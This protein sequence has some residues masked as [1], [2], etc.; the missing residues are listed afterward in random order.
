MK[1]PDGVGAK[2]KAKAKAKVTD[3]GRQC[4]FENQKTRYSSNW[5]R[6]TTAAIDWGE[7]QL[8]GITVSVMAGL[9]P[10]IQAATLCAEGRR[11]SRPIHLPTGQARP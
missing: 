3:R 11:G 9:D 8:I 4:L 7:L 6:E 10:A 2:A 1:M 5:P